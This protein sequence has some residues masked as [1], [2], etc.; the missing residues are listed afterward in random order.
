MTSGTFNRSST[1]TSVLKQ[2]QGKEVKYFKY[3]LIGHFSAPNCFF[4]ALL[5]ALLILRPAI[6][7]H[8]KTGSLFP[9]SFIKLL[10][11]PFG[12]L[13]FLCD[14]K[15]VLYNYFING[16]V[17]IFYSISKGSDIKGNLGQ[18]QLCLGG[19]FSAMSML[20]AD[21]VDPTLPTC[22]TFAY[23]CYCQFAYQYFYAHNPT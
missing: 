18:S 22:V 7:Q 13:I 23:F 9:L 2:K 11:L 20:C 8:F 15:S 17:N 21:S 14:A 3:L 5:L 1:S 6:K 16:S 12:I 19:R 10:K 4:P